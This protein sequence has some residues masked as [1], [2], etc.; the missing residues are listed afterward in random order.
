MDKRSL[1][2]QDGA[3]NWEE[4]FRK[5]VEAEEE[6]PL[7]DLPARLIERATRNASRAHGALDKPESWKWIDTHL[8]SNHSRTAFIVSVFDSKNIKPDIA[9]RFLELAV[10]EE[11]ISNSKWFV[12]PAVK[13]L[14]SE[15]VLEILL[16][17]LRSGSNL[18]KIGAVNAK[19]WVGPSK[20]EPALEKL[21]T[22]FRDQMRHELDHNLDPEVQRRFLGRVNS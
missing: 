1:K 4:Q 7:S 10:K 17:Y 13:A 16:G 15:R 14:G 19:Y 8:G 2:D 3:M 9:E 11:N 6:N 21:H 18:Q 12:R 5:W 22:E 20:G